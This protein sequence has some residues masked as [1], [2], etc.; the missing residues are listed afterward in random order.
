MVTSVAPVMNSSRVAVK[1]VM[2]LIVGPRFAQ[3]VE[4]L[5]MTISVLR[6]WTVVMM[7]TV[8]RSNTL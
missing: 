3:I 5:C 1:T 8:R 2:N 7:A 4:S 6:A